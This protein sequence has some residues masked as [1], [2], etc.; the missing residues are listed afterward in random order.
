MAGL[1]K[2]GYRHSAFVKANTSRQPCQKE[3]L[4]ATRIIFFYIKTHPFSTL[5]QGPSLPDEY[6]FN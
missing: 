3:E 6:G 4:E 5:I 2:V 1:D